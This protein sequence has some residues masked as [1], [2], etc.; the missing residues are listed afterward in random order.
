MASISNR[1]HMSLIHAVSQPCTMAPCIYVAMR[2]TQRCWLGVAQDGNAVS[3][4]WAPHGMEG[5]RM[6]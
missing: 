5:G 2:C 3:C 4:S 6:T 1:S